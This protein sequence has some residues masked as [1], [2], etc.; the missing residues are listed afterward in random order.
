MRF[1]Y[2]L[3]EILSIKSLFMPRIEQN[4]DT[5]AIYMLLSVICTEHND[6]LFLTGS[7]KI[8]TFSCKFIPDKLS[9][10][11][12][13]AYLTVLS[14]SASKLINSAI[15]F[16]NSSASHFFYFFMWFSL[17]P[18]KSS[19]FILQKLL[20]IKAC[21]IAASNLPDMLQLERLR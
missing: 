11:N 18:L 21:G 15:L 3:A 13:L 20:S 8:I 17:F 6:L 4:S 5:V 10:V 16:K 9:D 19:L 12:R 1:L 2:L 7:A 14:S